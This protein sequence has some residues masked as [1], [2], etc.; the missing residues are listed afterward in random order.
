MTAVP[1]LR[2]VTTPKAS[3]EAMDGLLLDHA[4]SRLVASSG[5][6]VAF[7]WTV[8]AV[9]AGFVKEKKSDAK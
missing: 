7:N 4:M 6:T 9:E 3:T 8:G 2:A 1:A 5:S